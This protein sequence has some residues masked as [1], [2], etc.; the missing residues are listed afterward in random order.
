[1]S[2]DKKGKGTTKEFVVVFDRMDVA[3]GEVQ[4]APGM[5]PVALTTSHVRGDKVQLN[6]EEA[7]RHLD[8]GAVLPASDP[9]AKNVKAN[10]LAFGGVKRDPA[11]A[12]LPLTEEPTP[13]LDELGAGAKSKRGTSLGTK[14]ALEKLGNARLKELA[15]QHGV[16]VEAKDTKKTLAAKLS[17]VKVAAGAGDET[18]NPGQGK[19]ESAPPEHQPDDEPK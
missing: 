1:M 6:D 14:A 2:E 10:D 18:V 4:T 9:R 17:K 13:T 19:D 11:I 5:H 8:S 3:T 7:A 16:E 15:A 12:A